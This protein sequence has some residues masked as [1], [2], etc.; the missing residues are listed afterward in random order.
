MQ[1]HSWVINVFLVWLKL[2]NNSVVKKYQKINKKS[3]EM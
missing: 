3:I 2:N 1:N